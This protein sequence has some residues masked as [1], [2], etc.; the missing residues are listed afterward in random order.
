MLQ[1]K[2]PVLET[3]LCLTG[4]SRYGHGGY[5]HGGD[6]RGHGHGHGGHDDDSSHQVAKAAD[7]AEGDEEGGN[8]DIGE[9]RGV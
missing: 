2:V 7:N 1:K 3:K 9:G 4:H 6:G 8:D 5:G